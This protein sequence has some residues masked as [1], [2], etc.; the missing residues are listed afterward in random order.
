MNVASERI[1]YISPAA[2]VSMGDDW[3]GIA[4]LNHFWIERRFEVLRHLA[5]GTIRQ[6]SAIAEVGC[7]HG[8][9]QRQIEDHY[10]RDVTGFDLNELALNQTASRTS[11]VCCYDLFQKDSEFK[12]HF[13]LI[14]L[15]DVLEHLQDEDEFVEAIQFHLAPQGKILINVPALQSLWSKYDEAAGHFRRY[16]IEALR[17]VAQR[18]G[19]AIGDWSYWGAPLTPLLVLRKLLLA[20]RPSEKVISTGFDPRNP[21]LNRLLF[22]LSRCEQIPQHLA[23]TSVM[24]VFEP[25]R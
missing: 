23:G 18:N 22:W 21:V 13:D 16:N 5:D 24:A 11:K 10:G 1:R 20:A 15:F 14:L 3:Y 19:M 2:A 4:S 25:R 7:G 12:G 9:V 6:A 17:R 8:L